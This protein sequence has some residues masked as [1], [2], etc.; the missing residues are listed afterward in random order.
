M[1]QINLIG[2][3]GKEPETR[4]TDGGKTVARMT[5]AVQNSK[6]HTEWFNIVA[7]EQRADTI[8]KYAHKGDVIAITGRVETREYEKD[9]EKKRITEVIAERV[10]LLPNKK[11]EVDPAPAH[12]QPGMDNDDLPF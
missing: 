8:S 6:D 9:G 1:N 2:R 11:A 10:E 3:I 4:T 7:W 5:L 12:Q